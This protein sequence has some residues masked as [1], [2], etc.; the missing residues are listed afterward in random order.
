[1]PERLLQILQQIEHDRLHR[2]VERRGRLVENDQIGLQRDR[3]RDADAR[4]LAA[5]S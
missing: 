4:L 3:A 1:M 5:G 2:D